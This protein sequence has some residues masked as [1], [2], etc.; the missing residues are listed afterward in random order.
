MEL[1][2][3]VFLMAFDAP[4]IAPSSCSNSSASTLTGF[5][6][7]KPG[8]ALQAA[9]EAASP[10][11]AEG[12]D[13]AKVT[14]QEPTRRSARLSAKPAPPKPEPK[15]RK[16][17]KKE[18]G[19]KANKGAKGKKDEKQE[20]AKEGTTPSEN[21]ENKAEEIRISRS[22]VSVSTSRGAPASTLSV[23]GQIETVKA[24][25]TESVGD[26]NE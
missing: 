1:L 7:C 13:A 11:G 18:P 26:K 15:P 23:K 19:T 6:H 16:T 2:V 14:K 24:Q 9:G 4:S 3:P 21:G 10:E 25:K 17:T 12:K 8:T 20:A 22:A 5:S